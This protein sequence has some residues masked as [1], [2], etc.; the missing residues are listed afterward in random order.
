[1]PETLTAREHEIALMIAA[2]KS[3]GDIQEATGLAPG[4]LKHHTFNIYRKLGVKNE[5]ELR[6]K[7]VD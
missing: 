5:R 1:M 4:T 7:G 6:R 3:P 2:D